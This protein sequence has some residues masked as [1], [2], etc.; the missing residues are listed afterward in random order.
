MRGNRRVCHSIAGEG[1]TPGYH[2][3]GF[4]EFKIGL[5]DDAVE[6]VTYR[7]TFDERNAQGKQRFVVRRIPGA[8]ATD[9]HARATWWRAAAGTKR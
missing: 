2:A 9:P 3:E 1:R 6:D 4:Y 8:E 5:D 7:I